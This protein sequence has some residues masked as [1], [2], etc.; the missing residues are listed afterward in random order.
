MLLYQMWF[1]CLSKL[2]HPLVPGMQL[3]IWKMLFSPYL[4]IRP[5]RSSL[6]S[7]GKASNTPLLS[8]LRGIST[9]QPYVIIQFAGILH[10]ISHRFITLMTLC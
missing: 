8:Y 9:L 6:L 10:K 4:L 5:T 3:L 2:T 7:A 1:H